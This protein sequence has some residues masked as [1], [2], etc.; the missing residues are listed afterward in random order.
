MSFTRRT[1]SGGPLHT[2]R[3]ED[4]HI[5]KNAC[6]HRQPSRHRLN[7]SNDDNC[8]HVWRLRG[9][10]LNPAFALQRYTPPTAGMMV[11]GVIAYN[12]RLP[13]VL[14]R[15]TITAQRYVHSIL[16]PHVLPLKQRL[17]GAIFPIA[18]VSQDSLLIV[19]TLSCLPNHQICVQ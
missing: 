7:L 5:L 8:V 12:T 17:P 3:R 13:L 6:I 2:S 4:R 14:I 1:G 10:R 15:G 18:R 19:T 16:Q 11:W 9:Q